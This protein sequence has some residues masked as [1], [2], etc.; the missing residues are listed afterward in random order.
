MNQRVDDAA[1]SP[2]RTKKPAALKAE[3][4]TRTTPS[5]R[6]K[7]N[8]VVVDGSDSDD[9]F[10]G[11][12]G[13]RNKA[14]ARGGSKP[15]ERKRLRRAA[16]VDEDDEDDVEFVAPSKPRASSAPA[17]KKEAPVA[18][19]FVAAR[20]AVAAP[21]AAVKA[22]V[23][24]EAQV[25]SEDEDSAPIGATSAG[26]AP[27]PCAGCLDGKSFVFSGELQNL[28]RDEAVHL[29]KCCGGFVATSV[30]KA[31]KYLVVGP[32]LP[33]GG[34]VAS[35]A[36]YKDAVAKNVRILQQNQFFN[37][38]TE[39]AAQK[40]RELLEKE[41]HLNKLKAPAAAG[42]TKQPAAGSRQVPADAAG[43]HDRER[44]AREAHQA[45]ACGLGRR[46]REGHE[47][48][49]V[50]QQARGEPRREDGP[51]LGAA[52]DRQDHARDPR[53]SR[54][55]LRVH[56]AERERHAQQEDAPDGA[57]GRAGLARTAVR[58]A[59][60]KR[61]DALGKARDRDGRGGRHVGRRPRGHGRAHSA[62]QEVQDAGHLHLQRPTEHEGAVA[63]EPLVRPAHAPA[64][65]AADQ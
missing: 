32:S 7:Q 42:T 12:G 17:V 40:Q 3:T 29:V 54:V 46:A 60:H 36:K 62:D 49:P 35:G 43:G 23:K 11:G 52:G 15:A 61:R 48:N 30:S 56:G 21:A 53:G 18:K 59:G 1:A 45:V 34:D 37:L 27:P 31:T 50:Q 57:Q 19:K 26:K 41:K 9:D 22:E 10:E 55:R 4:P 5:R 14:T 25:K 38:I 8:V 44:G 39:A 28:S 20:T 64:D 24:D 51:A 65:E 2:A 33:D 13:G 6:A 63:R 16:D 58:P 47:E